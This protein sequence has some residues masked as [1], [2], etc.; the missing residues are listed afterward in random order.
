Y[1]A[2][3]RACLLL[4]RLDAARRF[5]HRSVQSSRHQ[6]GFTA[7]ALRLFGDIATVPEGFDAESGAAYYRDA[8]ALARRLGMRPLVAH[9]HPGPPALH[10]RAGNKEHAR[11]YFT[12]A[13][14]MYR[15][16]EMGFWVNQAEAEVTNA[17]YAEGFSPV[18][19]TLNL[20]SLA[21]NQ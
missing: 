21:S 15:E 6:R 4:G 19:E 14:I 12:S 8:L 17:D 11:D 16:M 5:G 20:R 1:G 7:H 13:T 3:G 10:R 9:C 2:V 18:P